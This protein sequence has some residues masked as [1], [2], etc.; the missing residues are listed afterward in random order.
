MKPD[1]SKWLFPLGLAALA[2]LG[3]ALVLYNTV[4]GAYLSDDSFWYIY[5]ARQ[6]LAGFPFDPSR[7]FAPLLPALLWLAGLA[8]ADPLASL[9][10][11][12]ALFFGLNLV[13]C[14]LIVRGAGAS[15]GWALAAA[16]L[17]LVSDVVVELHGWGM[18]EALCLTAT[19]LAVW[20]YQLYSQRGGWR[21]LALAALGAALAC[22]ARYAAL[23]LVGA[24]A[25]DLLLFSKGG[26][27]KR[28]GLA[29]GFGAAAALPLGLY[30]LRNQL[31]T[32]Q[33]TNYP[34]FHWTWPTLDNLTWFCYSTLSWFVP[35]RFLKE[36]E[37]L[38]GAAAAVVILAALAGL[39]LA[40]R[41]K[42]G[43]WGRV[44][45]AGLRVLWVN[46]LLIVVMLVV[47]NG[48]A[49]LVAFNERYLVQLLLVLLVS[50]AYWAG[51]AWQK[52]G[53]PLRA[54]LVVVFVA[55]GVYYAGRTA[56]DARDLH[57]NGRGYARAEAA[58]AETVRFLSAHADRPFFATGP[59]GYYFW[60]GVYR[61]EVHRAAGDEALLAQW[62]CQQG[63][64]L[65]I[66]NGMPAEMYGLQEDLLAQQL[67]LDYTFSDGRV[68]SC[69]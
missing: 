51:L 33:A 7:M 17:A 25:L 11:L 32:G 40:G 8:G 20:A 63:A 29:A 10:W 67:R 13:F 14:G 39:A 23:P 57:A 50:L 5:P 6:A 62:V 43:L 27:R 22:L 64:Y 45:P 46:G 59:E 49:N 36:R 65:V 58:A 30:L 24:L 52:A 35:G 15:R 48:L 60:L 68:Y 2:L 55:F 47:S 31:L 41:R 16:A 4:W 56:S 26:W 54:A 3:A 34:A 69:P 66:H 28:L 37:L 19:L 18:S 42:A 9:R 44:F 61:D 21:W 53:L 1:R 12:N 38:F